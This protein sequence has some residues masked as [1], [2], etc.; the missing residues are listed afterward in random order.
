MEAQL[1]FCRAQKLTWKLQ[2]ILGD[3]SK[4][5]IANSLP[6]A[7]TTSGSLE[8]PFEWDRIRRSAAPSPEL[9]SKESQKQKM[10]ADSH[11]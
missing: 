10:H 1:I 11:D 8:A 4:P 3:D 5:S 7:D 9:L 2:R 6:G